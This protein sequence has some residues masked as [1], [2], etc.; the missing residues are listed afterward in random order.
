MIESNIKLNWKIQ[1]TLYSYLLCTMMVF[2][3][4]FNQIVYIFLLI[5]VIVHYFYTILSCFIHFTS[6]LPHFQRGLLKYI[7]HLVIHVVV[8]VITCMQL[9]QSVVFFGVLFPVQL[10]WFVLLW[11]LSLYWLLHY[12]YQLL[13]KNVHQFWKLD[14]YLN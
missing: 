3:P 8:Y 7:P 2:K 1:N 13:F 9:F 14:N 10:K 12:R 4:G 11:I 6:Q 5:W